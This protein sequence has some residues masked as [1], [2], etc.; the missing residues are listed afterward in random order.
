MKFSVVIPCYCSYST[1][2]DV[3]KSVFETMASRNYSQSDFEIILVNDNSRDNTIELIY[4]LCD[5]YEN[6]VGI[7]FA[8]NFGQASALMAGFRASKGEYIITA[9]DDGQSPIDE[10]WKMYDRLVSDDKYDIVCAKNSHVKKTLLREF[11]SSAYKFMIYNLLEVP[12][13][14]SPSIYFVARRYLIDE[15][16]KYENPYPLLAGL[17]NR[18]TSKIG[19]VEINRRKRQ[20]GSSGYTIKK[21]LG[22]WLNGVT[23]FS[24]KPLRIA[25]FIGFVFAVLGLLGVLYLICCKIFGR[26]TYPG[27]TSTISVILLVGGAILCILGIIGEYVGRIYMC[28]NN[29][30]QYVIRGIKD[31]RR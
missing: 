26:L 21:L 23:A 2:S 1:L 14:V 22:V 12:K 11:G 25:T 3:V 24:I 29:Q 10:M 8:K 31:N 19:N 18:S 13:D 17:I 7:D 27:Y 4:E 15:I 6:I 16:T 30:P 9:E 20:A 28:I 5:K